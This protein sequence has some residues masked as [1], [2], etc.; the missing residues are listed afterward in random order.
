MEAN[1]GLGVDADDMQT[2]AV[3]LEQL[4]EQPQEH[5]ADLLVLWC[6]SAR[7]EK[8]MAGAAEEP[9]ALEPTLQLPPGPQ[10]IYYMAA[11]R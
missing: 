2:P 10:S 7:K 4:S 6:G 11:A 3:A 8:V 1:D 9:C 5:C